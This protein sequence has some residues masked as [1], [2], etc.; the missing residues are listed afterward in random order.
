MRPS[1]LIKP[2]SLQKYTPISS[3]MSLLIPTLLSKHTDISL[4][5]EKKSPLP[6]ELPKPELAN[7]FRKYGEDFLRTN[8]LSHQQFKVMHAIKDCRSKRLGYHLDICDVCG[9]IEIAYNSCRNRHCPK[10]QSIARRKWVQA[11]LDDLL[12]ISYFHTVFT[13]PHYIFP[14]SLYNKEL[15]Y[16][17]LFDSAAQT[18][19]DFGNDPKHMGA[20]IGFYGILH[21]WGGALW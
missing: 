11:R 20:K 10:C 4:T 13:L 16:E 14:L 18:L 2:N 15:F 8:K 3:M 5:M 12:P 17:L 7:I 6:Q 9:H 19:L 21:T 1:P